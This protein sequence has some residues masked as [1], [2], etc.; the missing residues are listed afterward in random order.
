MFGRPTHPDARTCQPSNAPIRPKTAYDEQMEMLWVVIGL[1]VLALVFMIVQYNGLVSLRQ[2]TRNA[3]AD[4][5]VYLKR[6]AELIPNLVAAVQAF[7]GHEKALL[8]SLA[9]AR[10]RA[11]ALGGPTGEKAAAEAEVGEQLGRTL[12]LAESYPDLKS[13]ENF[14][15]LQTEL[16]ETEGLIANARRYYNACVR[17]LN[18][19]IE[20]FPSSLAAGVAGVRAESFF[21]LETLVERDVPSIGG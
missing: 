19:K 21:E 15:R 4:V 5:D 8:E 13:A 1:G 3:W 9:D 11:L 10:S 14:T 6:R 12:I 17:D 20:S 7:A 16:T 2:L 18:T